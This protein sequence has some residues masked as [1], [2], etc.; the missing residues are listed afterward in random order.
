MHKFKEHIGFKIA[1]LLL[2]VALFT[3]T[4]IKFAHIFYH[5]YE[6]CNEYKAHL[7]SSHLDCTFH[8]FKHSTPYTI[9][10]FSVVFFTPEH[11]HEYFD[12]QY[13]F[14]SKYQRLHF[15]LRGPPYLI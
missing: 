5:K 11:N 2:V 13:S 15:S 7:H 10:Q 3:P 1:T 6:T 12:V 14:L 9:P 8:K 4:A